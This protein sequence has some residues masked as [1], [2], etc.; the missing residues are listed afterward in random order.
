MLGGEIFHQDLNI[1]L[2]LV[3][4]IKKETC[5]PIYVWTGFTWNDLLKDE[6]KV[7]ILNYIDVII[8][9]KFQI[10]KKDLTLKYRGSTNQMIIDVQKSLKENKIIEYN[11]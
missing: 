7:K 8:D 1:I 4:R 9:G 2:N 6:D 3:K 11:C 10:D 5:K